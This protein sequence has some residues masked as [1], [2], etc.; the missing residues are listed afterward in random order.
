AVRR[1]AFLDVAQRLIQAVGYEQMSV[2]DVLDELDASRGAFYHYFKSKVALLEAVCDRMVTV[3]LAAVAPV[4]DDPA[5]TAPEKL[6]RL[7]AGIGHWKAE[8][9][10]LILAL[11][12]VWRSDDNAL[13]REKLRQETMTRLAPLL[14][15]I[16]AQ[17]QAE[18]VFS[19]TSPEDA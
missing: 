1:D 11:I 6:A 3:A 18:G 2:Q 19:V 12:R 10:D 14:A 5:L 7:F 15:R 9:R 4:V 13:V 8:R 17:G 16:I